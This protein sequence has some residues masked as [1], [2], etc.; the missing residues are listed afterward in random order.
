MET[1]ATD[2]NKTDKAKLPGFALAPGVETLARP[3]TKSPAGVY[4][5]VWVWV[6]VC[7]LSTLEMREGKKAATCGGRV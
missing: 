4:R 2:A 5:V 3:F 6:W 1:R 7:P